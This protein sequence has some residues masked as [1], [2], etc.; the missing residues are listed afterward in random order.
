MQLEDIEL[1]AKPVGELTDEQLELRLI[2]LKSLK[3][4]EEKKKTLEGTVKVT[5]VRKTNK[6][7]QVDDLLSKLTPEAI[8]KL[9]E[10]YG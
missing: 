7:K 6:D 2:V 3:F 8:K 9:M 10:K 1:L 4:K 5:K